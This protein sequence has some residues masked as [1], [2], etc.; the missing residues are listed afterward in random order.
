MAGMTLRDFRVFQK[1][2]LRGFAT[3]ELPSGL[4]V[5]DVTVHKKNGTAW[6]SFPSV[7]QLENGQHRVLDGKNQ[8]KRILEWRDR[9]LGDRFSQAVVSLVEEKFPDALAV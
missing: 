2:T 8:Y 3:L 9:D 5:H 6:A 7:P 4:I 1:N